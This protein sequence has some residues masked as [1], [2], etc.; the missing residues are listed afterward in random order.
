MNERVRLALVISPFVVLGLVAF[1]LSAG[2]GTVWALA[3]LGAILA[4]G[5]ALVRR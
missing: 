5:Y 4:S 1:F 2:S 3:L